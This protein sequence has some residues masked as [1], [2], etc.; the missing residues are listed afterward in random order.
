MIT[1]LMGAGFPPESAVKIA[2]SF[3]PSAEI[4]D[5]V[6][7]SISEGEQGGMNEDLWSM[8]QAGREV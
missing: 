6:M 8:L 5:E 1:S 4:S 7:Q 3:V 2:K